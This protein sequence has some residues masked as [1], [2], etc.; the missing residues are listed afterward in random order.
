[1]SCDASPLNFLAA[2]ISWAV[3]S[4]FS[5]ASSSRSVSRWDPAVREMDT[6]HSRTASYGI[7]MVLTAMD[8]KWERF[9]SMNDGLGLAAA[10]RLRFFGDLA[11]T[12]NFSRNAL[13]SMSTLTSCWDQT[14]SSVSMS[15]SM[16]LMPCTRTSFG[17]VSFAALPLV[18]LAPPLD[19]NSSVN[20]FFIGLSGSS[21]SSA[22]SNPSIIILCATAGL[23][24]P[25]V[26]MRKYTDS[27]GSSLSAAALTYSSPSSF[28][29][30]AASRNR[31]GSGLSGSQSRISGSTL[32]MRILCCT[33]GFG[34][35]AL[36]ILKYANS[37]ASSLMGGPSSWRNRFGSG[38]SWSHS[39][40]SGF[41]PSICILCCTAGI[42]TPALSIFRYGRNV[43]SSFSGGVSSRYCLGNGFSGSQSNTSGFT[44]SICI[45]CCTAGLGTPA[46]SILKYGMYVGSSFSGGVLSTNL[47]GS[48]CVG[49]Q[50]RISGSTPS[51]CILC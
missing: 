42:G 37:L 39:K 48:G 1:M 9:E 47:A 34:T 32:S 27:L 28:G 21:S 40:I 50:S 20:F 23:G 24:T 41:R 51:I 31:F 3:G 5:S 4:A 14:M 10:A 29:A 22:G 30:T 49:S 43:G 16:A 38:L 35:P 46:L 25:R 12:A 26:N 7:L 19:L 45:L 33:A 11:F 18:P 2:R 44:P 8:T 15:S 36:S 6:R 17:P 13:S